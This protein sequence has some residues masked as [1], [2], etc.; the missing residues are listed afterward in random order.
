MGYDTEENDFDQKKSCYK[1]NIEGNDVTWIQKVCEQ[2]FHVKAVIMFG[3]EFAPVQEKE[4]I[5]FF[6]SN[7]F[8]LVFVRT[9]LNFVCSASGKRVQFLVARY[10]IVV[11]GI[12]HI[13]LCNGL[14]S[15]VYE[16]FLPQYGLVRIYRPIHVD[17]FH[18]HSTELSTA[19]I[20]Y[21]RGVEKY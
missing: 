15:L 13:L 1:E 18:W 21:T 10:T 8:T 7:S 16:S 4:K 19:C 3:G 20:E 9:L 11:H 14:S 17:K 5:K 6:S 12:F 2:N